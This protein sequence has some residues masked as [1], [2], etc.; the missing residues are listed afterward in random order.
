M[1]S[2]SP[3]RV[4]PDL[5]SR[6]STS[7]K[8]VCRYRQTPPHKTHARASPASI[9]SGGAAPPQSFRAPTT[10]CGWPACLRVRTR[11]GS[12]VPLVEGALQHERL[13]KY[14]SR[15]AARCRWPSRS[16]KGIDQMLELKQQR[17]A[18]TH[19][20]SSKLDRRTAQC[21]KAQRSAARTADVPCEVSV[22]QALGHGEAGVQVRAWIQG[23]VW[24]A[25][26]VSRRVQAGGLPQLHGQ[27]C[28][29]ARG[30][31]PRGWGG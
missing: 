1:L 15:P 4:L 7:A 20:H 10:R 18:R 21:S 11:Q 19:E 9:P 17:Q 24:Q 29:S 2:V 14:G 3:R 23:G 25:Q 31:M 22:H 8:Q 16:V 26:Q 12:R 13:N 6:S 27:A 5:K 28:R 30:G